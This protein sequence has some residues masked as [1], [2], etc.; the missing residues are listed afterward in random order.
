MASATQKTFALALRNS[1]LPVPDGLTSWNAPRPIRR[2]GVYRS[3]VMHGLI[4]AITSRFPAA[5]RIVGEEFFAAMA[6]EFVCKY[7]PQSPLLLN[8]GDDFA[9]FVRDFEPAQE[10]AYLA[11]IIR[12][13]TV[14]SKA[15]HSVD[16]IPAGAASLAAIPGEHA[17]NIS[18]ILHPSLFIVQSQH[19]VVTIWAMNTGEIEVEPI[20]DWRSEDALVVRPYMKVEVHRL[21]VGGAAFLNAI[22]RGE[23]LATAASQTLE[24]TPG[25]DLSANLAS[26]IQAGAFT[27]ISIGSHK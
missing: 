18:F 3:N 2:F 20:A 22:G 15:Y 8:Y 6:Y 5:E 16:A 24:T 9:D 4:G 27:A 17:E 21:P 25:F 26:A 19:P 10:I 13:E 11:D 23:K 12:L 7:P 14:R 1:K